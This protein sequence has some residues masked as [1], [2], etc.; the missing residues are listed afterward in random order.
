MWN[1]YFRS[2]RDQMPH[3]F[4]QTF[5]AKE[6]TKGLL[7]S[8]IPFEP[9]I[10]QRN[11]LHKLFVFYQFALI[12]IKINIIKNCNPY[13]LVPKSNHPFLVLK[14]VTEMSFLVLKIISVNSEENQ[15]FM[16]LNCSLV[17]KLQFGNIDC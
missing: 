1:D 11:F 12:S 4:L 10:F 16:L 7:N 17:I 9:F 2:F 6:N 14:G 13:C 5:Y 3:I 8:R 15:Y